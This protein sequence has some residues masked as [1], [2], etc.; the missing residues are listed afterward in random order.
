[1][2]TRDG[3]MLS[4]RTALRSVGPLLVGATAGCLGSGGPDADRIRWQKRIRGAPAL[5]GDALYVLD[6]LTVFALSSTDGAERWTVGYDEDQFDRRLCLRDDIVVDD[7]RLY[8]PACDGLRALHRSDGEQVWSVDAPLRGAAAAQSGRVYAKSDELLAIDAETG[9][10]D[11]RAPVGGERLTSPAA[12]PDA[13]VVADRPEGV[14]TAFGVDGERR[15]THRTD[16]ETRSPTV[17]D[18]TVYVATAPDPGRAGRLLALDLAGGTVQWA[19]D[20]P[21]L[22]R[23]TRPVVGDESVYL[24]C[25]SRDHGTLV[26]RSRDDGA[27]QWSFTDRNSSVYQPVLAGDRVYVGS[28]DD[29][30]YAF[31]RSGDRQWRIGTGSTVGSVAVGPDYVYASNNERLIAVARD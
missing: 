3:H 12:T 2:A 11:W 1:M 6:R 19:V 29:T 22:K 18:G 5:A 31:S 26:A 9:A 7:N 10:V 8:V 28:N 23:G 15:W 25:S 24:G 4:R 21:S 20:T 27:E 17:R 13:V 16:A 14:V 30:L